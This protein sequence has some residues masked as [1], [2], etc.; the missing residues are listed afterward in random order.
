[1][2]GCGKL[3]SFVSLFILLLLWKL[4]GVFAEFEIDVHIFCCVGC[5]RFNVLN[6]YG[7]LK[8]NTCTS[9][10]NV[11]GQGLEVT[12]QINKT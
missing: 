5:C 4:V 1:M 9:K 6:N 8:F 11:M 10:N 3:S 7:V 2:G 12:F